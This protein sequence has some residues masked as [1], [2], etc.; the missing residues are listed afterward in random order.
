[1]K[2]KIYVLFK[3]DNLKMLQNYL[4]S[5]ENISSIS[6][7]FG[8]FAQTGP[9][10]GAVVE[11][12]VSSA[13]ELCRLAQNIRFQVPGIRKT[14][15][16]LADA[17]HESGFAAAKICRA[18]FYYTGEAPKTVHAFNDLSQA[19]SPELP[20]PFPFLCFADRQEPDKVRLMGYANGKTCPNLDWWQKQVMKSLKNAQID[21]PF[22]HNIFVREF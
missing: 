1:M 14:V 16:F 20:S 6:E 4:H 18:S 17:L 15:I 22:V 19:G 8:A 13:E 12:E 9:A 21:G 11:A 3:T 10:P 5:Q 7:A 2:T